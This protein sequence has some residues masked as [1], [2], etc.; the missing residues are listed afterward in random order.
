MGFP[1]LGSASSCSH[2][3][4]IRTF[5]HV[6]SGILL[7]IYVFSGISNIQ[8]PSSFSAVLRISCLCPMWLSSCLCIYL[9]TF[10]FTKSWGI[11]KRGQR[12]LILEPM[13]NALVRSVSE[14]FAID[15]ASFIGE[16][17]TD[18]SVCKRGHT[19]WVN[20]LI[21]SISAFSVEELGKKE[22]SLLSSWKSFKRCIYINHGST[23]FEL[24]WVQFFL[25]FS[26]PCL[27]CF[28]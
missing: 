6:S 8:F 7:Q 9:I 5:D 3:D 26:F 15:G 24:D 12:L 20:F 19:E 27:L 18:G 13:M 17:F 21:E 14:R 23:F 11:R 2:V 28:L 1:S 16:R 10:G 4:R 22:Y 25:Q